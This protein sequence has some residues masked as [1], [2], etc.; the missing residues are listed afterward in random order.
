M[1]IEAYRII[2]KISYQDRTTIQEVLD[3]MKKQKEITLT[4][5]TRKLQY[6]GY[7]I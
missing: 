1:E 7:I 2:K 5:K 6:Q 3:R 4:I